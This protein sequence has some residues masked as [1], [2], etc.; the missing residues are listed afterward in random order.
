MEVDHV[1][2]AVGHK[3]A[4]H[5]GGQMGLKSLYRPHREVRLGDVHDV[6]KVPTER[7]DLFERGCQQRSS[8]IEINFEVLNLQNTNILI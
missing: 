7:E 4:A 6:V 3:V 2:L 1:V 8:L 5:S